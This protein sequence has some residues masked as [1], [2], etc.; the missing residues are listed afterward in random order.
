VTETPGSATGHPGIGAALARSILPACFLAAS[1]TW[2]IGMFLPVLL[3]QRFGFGGWIVFAFFN[4]AGAASVGVVL[5]RP[6]AAL[7]FAE[8]HRAAIGWF[9][10]VTIAFHGYAFAWIARRT[11]GGPAGSVLP[12]GLDTGPAVTVAMSLF[13]VCWVAVAVLDRAWARWVAV[14]VLLASVSSFV[15]ASGGVMVGPFQTPIPSLPATGDPGASV[16]GLI[17]AAPAIAAGFLACPYLDATL[18]RERQL[19]A[20]PAGSLAFALGFGGPFLVMI[21]MTLLYA[22]VWH[23]HRSLPAILMVH[24]LLQTAFTAG[25]HT[26]A[27][28]ATGILSTRSGFRKAGAPRISIVKLFA[29]TVAIGLML[30][31]GNAVQDFGNLRPGLS[32]GRLGYEAFISLYALVFPA[33]AWICVAPWTPLADAPMRTRRWVLAAA[34]A[35]A[36]GPFAFG[37]IADAYWLIPVAFAVIMAAPWLAAPFLRRRAGRQ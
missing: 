27:I 31:L 16:L 3:T 23:E 24:L 1:W 8:D 32:Y 25:V 37:F 13:V 7:R 6:G 29:A 18:N 30:P 10:L 36:A 14:F 33:Y 17:F 9:G 19:V 26:R 21:S 2:V 22:R 28:G 5:A 20:E 12:W 4:V 15:A 34:C 11:L 35:L